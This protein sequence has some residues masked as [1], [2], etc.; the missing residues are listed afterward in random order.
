MSIRLTI[1]IALPFI[2][3]TPVVTASVGR[4]S[5]KQLSGSFWIDD[6]LLMALPAKHAFLEWITIGD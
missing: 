6:A 2:S 5:D 3:P 1:K 4:L